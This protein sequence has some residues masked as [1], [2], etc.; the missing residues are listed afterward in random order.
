VAES[1]GRGLDCLSFDL[2]IR[3]IIKSTGL[4]P[5]NPDYPKPH[6][7]GAVLSFSAPPEQPEFPTENF[8]FQHV[9]KPVCILEQA[10]FYRL[11][12]RFSGQSCYRR[13]SVLQTEIIA[14]IQRFQLKGEMAIVNK[15]SSL[16][17]LDV[18]SRR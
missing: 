7:S 18:C 6:T 5:T 13:W 14:A 12:N 9:L 3:G 2:D 11:R 8:N 1:G 17:G 16:M 4:L 15:L 10:R